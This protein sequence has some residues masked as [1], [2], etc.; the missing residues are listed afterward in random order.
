MSIIDNV[1]DVAR[2]AQEVGKI[3]L[4]QKAVDLMAQVVALSQENFQLTQEVAELK[5]QLK[6]KNEMSYHDNVYWKDKEAFCPRCFDTKKL[7]VHVHEG[8]IGDTTYWRCPECGGSFNF[9]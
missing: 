7:A 6:L 3:E 4:Y 9:K 5:A 1:K 2:L 8:Y